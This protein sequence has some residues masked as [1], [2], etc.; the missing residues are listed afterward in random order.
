MA[1]K[2][3]IS[4]RKRIERPKPV[5]NEVKVRKVNENKFE[6]ARYRTSPRY[7]FLQY[8]TVAYKW[9]MTNYDITRKNLEL[10]FYLYGVGTFTKKEFTLYSRLS[11]VNARVI[12]KRL[13]DGGWIIIWRDYSR[14]N[15]AL[16]VLSDKAKKMCDKIHKICLGEILIS[17]D[18]RVNFI[19]DVNEKTPRINRYYMDVIKEMNKK[20]RGR[21]K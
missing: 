21:V 16:F 12:M 8:V 6:D 17:E 19:A 7:T 15:A 9:A 20:V 4:D 5:K 10:I 2:M 18:P 14:Y 13:I 3:F 11:N 1:Y